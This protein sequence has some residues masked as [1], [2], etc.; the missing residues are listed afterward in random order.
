MVPTVTLIQVVER[1]LPGAPETLGAMRKLRQRNID[2]F[3]SPVLAATVVV[4]AQQGQVWISIQP[5]FTW[6]A[7]M[8]PQ[9]VDELIRALAAATN[10]AKKMIRRH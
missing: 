9:Q 3:P 1:R 4:T 8:E 10:I 6:D 5:P 2:S 7:I